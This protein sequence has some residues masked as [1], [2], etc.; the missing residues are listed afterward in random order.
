MSI[1]HL[2]K[3]TVFSYKNVL[4]FVGKVGVVKVKLPTNLAN[5]SFYIGESHIK[6]VASKL[7]QNNVD[8]VK[9]ILNKIKKI[10]AKNDIGFTNKIMLLGIGFRSWT[11]KVSS[12]IEYLILKIGFS[13]DLSIRIPSIIKIIILKPTLILFK[14]LDKNALNQFVASLRSLKTPDSYKGKGLR[15]V[16]EKITLKVGK[17]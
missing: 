4:F 2:H 17:T 15:Y 10:L 7:N 13:R 1:I 9:D 12:D 8:L 14:S 6:I 3:S 5:I 11:Y 16:E